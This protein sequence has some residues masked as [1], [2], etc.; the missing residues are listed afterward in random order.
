MPTSCSPNTSK[1]GMAKNT[2]ARIA[3]YWLAFRPTLPVAATRHGKEA[4]REAPSSG[5]RHGDAAHHTPPRA[6]EVL[7]GHAGACVAL[8]M[9]LFRR[10]MP[11]STRPSR[12][13]SLPAFHAATNSFLVTL[14]FVLRPAL[15]APRS[16]SERQQQGGCERG[17]FQGI[18]G[19]R[20]LRRGRVRVRV[21]ACTK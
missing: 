6:R 4:A 1:H 18:H 2:T 16:A 10:M 8:T 9:L 3:S 15:C 13:A 11:R 20:G 21:R 5:K 7:H 14:S 17:T 19:K 12:N